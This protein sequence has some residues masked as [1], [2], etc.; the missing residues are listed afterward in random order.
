MF[1]QMILEVNRLRPDIE[2]YS[3]QKGNPAEGEL[4]A[5]M[6]E[7]NLPIVNLMSDVKDWMDTAALVS[8]MD[9]VVSVDTS[10]VH[11]AGAIG[12]PVWMMSR[13]DGCWRWF[14]RRT[15][16]PWYPTLRIFRQTKPR[17]WQPVV[18]EITKNL[19][20]FRP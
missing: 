11:L 18:D 12:R 15:D 2:F 16:S 4:A 17:D 14:L 9:L 3:I 10:M 19:I 7:T 13:L 8:N 1:E 6:A 5:R 20:D